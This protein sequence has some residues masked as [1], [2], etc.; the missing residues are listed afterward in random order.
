MKF[1]TN[2]P[3]LSTEQGSLTP[4]LEDIGWYSDTQRRIKAWRHAERARLPRKGLLALSEELAG[5]HN[6]SWKERGSYFSL[7]F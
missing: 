4:A 5:S 1:M 6:V 7:G 2:F 3:E